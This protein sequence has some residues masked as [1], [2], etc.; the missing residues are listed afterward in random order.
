MHEADPNPDPTS[1]ADMSEPL[2]FDQ[3]Q[4]RFDATQGADNEPVI[5]PHDPGSTRVEL[6]PELTF[7]LRQNNGKRYMLAHDQLMSR[8]FRLGINEWKIAKLMDGTRTLRKV[9]SD[10][11]E[12]VGQGN[13]S[14]QEVS[15]LATWLV[16]SGLAQSLNASPTQDSLVTGNNS[17]RDA[18]QGTARLGKWNPLFVRLTLPNPQRALER[19]KPYLS[20]LFSGYFLAIW[21]TVCLLGAQRVFSDWN[22]FR[23]SLRD[24]LAPENW[25]YL[26][27]V[28]VLLKVV[29]EV[30]HAIACMRW[31]GTVTRCG[32]MFVLF[33]PIAW[34]DVTSAWSL[35]SKWQ[36]IFVSAAGIYV[37]FFVAALAAIC[38]AYTDSPWVAT[39]TR[40]IVI[41]ASV[42]T[43]LFNSNFLMR[44]DGYYILSDLLEIENLY[45]SGQQY[46]TYWRRRYLLGMVARRPNHNGMRLH[47]VRVYGIA[48]LVWRVVF[49]VGILIV[50][51]QLF[52]GA[53]I[54]LAVFSAVIWFAIPLLQFIS[55]LLPSDA[56]EQP[57]CQRVGMVAGA[58]AVITLLG[59]YA[60]WPGTTSAAGFVEFSPL[61]TIRVQTPGFV[62]EVVVSPGDL[63]RQ[64]DVLLKLRN[65][66]VERELSDLELQI[67]I[68]EISLRIH[69]RDNDMSTYGAVAQKLASLREQHAHLSTR[70]GLLELRAPID[71]TVIAKHLTPLKGKYVKSGDELLSVGSRGEKEVRFSIPQHNIRVFRE[72]E[73][74][75]VSISIRGRSLQRATAT[76]VRVHPRATQNILHH[77]LASTNGGPLAVQQS[78]DDQQRVATHLVEPHFEGLV[79]LPHS[80]SDEVHAGELCFVSI[81]R[82]RIR[83]YEKLWYFAQ[84]F[85]EG[86]TQDTVLQART[87]GNIF[88]GTVDASETT[89]HSTTETKCLARRGN[90]STVELKN[91][92]PARG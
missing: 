30:G 78:S 83:V 64:G 36:R 59:L 38:W 2:D 8:Y 45:E 4:L 60:P 20:W 44:F 81:G 52:H 5:C 26:M 37:E 73:N 19:L 46:V 88:V 22:R 76:L 23:D 55:Q 47:L 51:A 21:L 49:C 25:L 31:G 42:T 9:I 56:A 80:L 29:H 67:R 63:V 84:R 41:S 77:G 32:L 82:G 15:R 75:D 34:V 24:V 68:Q 71:G 69:H 43:L 12:V 89:G 17:W 70:V 79:R 10:A 66:D 28:W 86:K 91:V 39:L 27:A 13:A 18:I 33:S 58:F 61:K 7:S 50:A 92:R 90:L 87:S 16:R 35:R 62:E 72:S 11:A 6:R 65:H 40:N 57:N 85:F 1:T 3:A 54:V 48:A 53:G 14:P 74:D